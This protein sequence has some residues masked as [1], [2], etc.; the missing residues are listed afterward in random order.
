MRC[1][2]LPKA[3]S[4]RLAIA[5]LKCRLINRKKYELCLIPLEVKEMQICKRVERAE[6]RRRW[7]SRVC[8]WVCKWQRLFGKQFG[9]T[10][11]FPGGSD[12]EE[13]VCNVGDLGLIPGW[14]R[15][16]EKGMAA[17]CRILTWRIPWTE[18]SGRPHSMGLQRVRHDGV[19]DTLTFSL[20]CDKNHPPP[21]LL[22][23][24]F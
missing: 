3:L 23:W 5:L 15:S 7:F 2:Y 24:F 4:R 20:W 21:T 17:H 16:L 18:E 11:G 8:W 12:G 13:S 10:R 1:L 22:L 14:E 19:T 6:M 9:V